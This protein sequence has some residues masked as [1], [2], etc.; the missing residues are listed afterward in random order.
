MACV[1]GVDREARSCS[2]VATRVTAQPLKS[3][4]TR[5]RR[6]EKL[7]A[8]VDDVR[9]LFAPVGHLTIILQETTKS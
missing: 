8:N 2:A 6:R 5:S 9:L 3:M 1:V 4:F 7:V